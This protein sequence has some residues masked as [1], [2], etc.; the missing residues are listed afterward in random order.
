[1]VRC[2]QTE[3][4]KKKGGLADKQKPKNIKR[5]RPLTTAQKIVPKKRAQVTPASISSKTEDTN[6]KA[7]DKV[8]QN[9]K[10]N[11]NLGENPKVLGIQKSKEPIDNMK[12][13]K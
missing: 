8:G 12:K 7:M 13:K 6:K 3:Y 1:M 4:R 2:I 9:S 10:K 11:N 5:A